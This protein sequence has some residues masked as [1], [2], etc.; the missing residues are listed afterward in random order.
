MAT[1]IALTRFDDRLAHLYGS[2]DAL[3]ALEDQPDTTDQTR[4][5]IKAHRALASAETGCKLYRARLHDMT[6]GRWRVDEHLLV[7]LDRVVAALEDEADK[8]DRL[9]RDLVKL[10]LPLEADPPRLGLA[11]ARQAAASFSSQV[12]P[13]RENSGALELAMFSPAQAQLAAPQAITGTGVRR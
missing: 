1:P 4:D 8:R 12:V 2:V 10:L 5:L 7:E 11:C 3:W 9:E 6:D 13:S